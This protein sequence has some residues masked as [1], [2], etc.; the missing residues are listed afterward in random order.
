MP[1]ATRTFRVFVSSTFEDLIEERNALQRDVFPALSKLC[2]THG[3][4]FQAIDLRWG[5][6]DEAVL[7]QKLME[8]C[9]AEIE[10]CQRTRIKPNFIVLLGDRYGKPP[11]PARVQAQE[12]E[13]VL[14]NMGSDADRVL[15]ESWYQRDENAVPAEYLLKPRSEEF[16]EGSHWREIE[17]PMREAL[18]R[19]ARAA[20]LGRD[21]LLKYE[22]S[23]SHQEIVKG[24]ATT[25]EDRKHV[26]AF[27]RAGDTATESDELT[28]LKGYLRAQLGDG[29]LEYRAGDIDKLCN[30]VRTSLEKVMLGEI[31][32]FESLP[33]LEQEKEAHQTFAWDR[34]QHFVGRQDVLGEIDK[35]LNDK[36][37]R[38]LVVHGPSG[39][40]KS[41]IIA[42]ASE[43]WRGI[44]RFV[45]ATPEASNGITLL[46][47][48]CEEI[49]ERYGQAG[50]LP[51]TFNELTVVFRD[52]LRLATSD[53][54]L[55]IYIDA[56]DQLGK[57]DPATAMNW[58][59]TELPSH[60][61]VVVSTI[62]TTPS[63]AHAKLTP[64]EPFSAEEAG[65]TLDLWMKDAKRALQKDQ[66]EK[67][68]ESFRRT[69]LPLYLKLAF[70]EARLWRS[71]DPVD[72][73]VLG[74]G[75][76][77]IID[78][79]FA[80]L[81]EPKHHGEVLVEHALGYLTAARYGLTEEEMLD[82]LA[83]DE[84]VWAD[85]ERAKK[86]DLLQYM[87]SESGKEKRRL[88]VIVWSRLYLDLEPYLTERIAPGGK[89]IAFY[90]RQLR[91]AVERRYLEPVPTRRRIHHLLADY[92]EARWQAPY[93]RALYSLP[94]HR[95]N[96]ADTEG[97]RR[98]LTD[99]SFMQAKCAEQLMDDLLGDYASAR[100]HFPPAEI[101]AVAPF[102]R[103][104][105]D[106]GSFLRKYPQ[107]LVQRAMVEAKGSCVAATARKLV[108]KL[109]L[110]YLESVSARPIES[111]HQIRLGGH[112]N[113]IRQLGYSD[114]KGFFSSDGRTIL[115]WDLS[116]GAI[117]TRLEIPEKYH[118]Y[119]N[120]K[121]IF[122]I[123][124]G[125][126]TLVLD[127]VVL[128]GR[129]GRCLCTFAFDGEYSS[130]PVIA[131]DGCMIAFGVS[132]P[133]ATNVRHYVHLTD[134][135]SG[136]VLD[137]LP[138]DNKV[139]LC[140]FSP[141]SRFLATAQER[142]TGWRTVEKRK[143]FG[144]EKTQEYQDILPVL[145][146]WDI[147]NR[148]AVHRIE[149][150]TS[151]WTGMEFST[152]CARLYASDP[153]EI[154]VWS[155]RDGSHILSLWDPDEHTKGVALVGDGSS[156]LISWGSFS[157]TLWDLQTRAK[158]RGL[159]NESRSWITAL[160]AFQ[161]GNSLGLG[162]SD[163]RIEVWESAALP[164]APPENPQS[165]QEGPPLAMK[166]C[167]ISADGRYVI[168]GRS[169]GAGLTLYELDSFRELAQRTLIDDRQSEDCKRCRFSAD[170]ES[171][172]M[173]SVA[174]RIQPRSPATYFSVLRRLRV[175]DLADVALVEGEEQ[176]FWYNL[177]ETPD[178]TFSIVFRDD[179]TLLVFEA[180]GLR[181][182]QTI[183]TGGN[184][185]DWC[186]SPNGKFVAF[187]SR[188]E[189]QV[190]DVASG[191][192]RLQVAAARYKR[193]AW[194]PFLQQPV[195]SP[196]GRLLAIGLGWGEIGIISSQTGQ[197]IRSLRFKENN[198]G[199]PRVWEFSPDGTKVLVASETFLSIFDLRSDNQWKCELPAWPGTFDSFGTEV[200]R[201]CFS[202]DNKF[203]FGIQK[204]YIQ[205][206]QAE[207]LTEV[208][209]DMRG[210][211]ESGSL[212]PHA[213]AIAVADQGAISLFRV[214]NLSFDP[215]SVT[216]TFLYAFKKH[217]FDSH[218]TAVCE[219][220]GARFQVPQPIADE[221]VKLE[222]EACFTPEDAPILSLPPHSWSVPRLVNDCF[223][224]GRKIRF[225]P[226][227]G[228][229]REL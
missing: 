182:H 97:V 134:T 20:G 105:Q 157:V 196:D 65:E 133:S 57:Q 190:R 38:P 29:V 99:L 131:P 185:S 18:Q 77:G 152:D 220:C 22:G 200:P 175:R 145:T 124:R 41:A 149:K 179:R 72:R 12:F 115:T 160:A 35:Y 59:P 150:H 96:A 78:Q 224:C 15:V 33:A 43:D 86:H 109:A 28:R 129:D 89:M 192:S 208:L 56:I 207:K 91:E 189:L 144:T 11:L 100:S 31:S 46:R 5:V 13:V 9:L 180:A 32:R 210:E 128:D 153:S 117:V 163:G 211:I 107:Y 186:L 19:A 16:V 158:E 37:T 106:Q 122:A 147:R 162:F 74:D 42:R 206:W 161:H 229:I 30:Q 215:P 169:S 67:L 102:A 39:S 191:G 126:S 1:V 216:A 66:R 227:L 69:R 70:E 75:L 174:F 121:S 80:R 165:A 225:N 171:V 202:R 82:V 120:Y 141:D 84:E 52:R 58:L 138:H 49:G 73:C 184:A 221:I 136:A 209:L 48:L 113:E 127:R 204:H 177:T 26:F 159:K 10:R 125:G 47:S 166:T 112:S 214:R 68:L 85:F 198:A 25:P 164:S 123:S 130:S 213:S 212:G 53:R 156:Q 104:V 79:L 203:V 218:A 87:L 168:A 111:S 94:F 60:C 93:P 23:A 217:Q 170:G 194:D 142:W 14:N 132:E 228:G 181:L 114:G 188:D 137:R 76:P 176:R 3:A 193:H 62:A 101:E 2:K 61:W 17:E 51:N 197:E 55:L 27:F 178:G 24:L 103:F 222:A 219:W 90:H 223:S 119:A 45:G 146:V 226:F 95:I 110:P 205:V 44:R 148:V 151:F 64:V 187:C 143:L 34:C 63:L 199:E 116:S 50:E 54:P 7:G 71:F 108:D 139:N 36:D 172:L 92:F 40:G 8:I 21:A 4:Q 81:S 98:V 183:K 88:P 140:C 83:A 201:F 135:L 195:Y 167:D 118:N 155:M 173:L 6:R 154:N